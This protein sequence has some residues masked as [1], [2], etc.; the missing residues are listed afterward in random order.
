M[1]LFCYI[2]LGV[3]SFG[4][5]AHMQYNSPSR[6]A[7]RALAHVILSMPKPRLMW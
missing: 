5:H 7:A 3:G 6:V 1:T 2:Y 4:A